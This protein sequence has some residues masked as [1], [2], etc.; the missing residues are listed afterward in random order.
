MLL[1]IFFA[2]CSFFYFP[3]ISSRSY[4]RFALTIDGFFNRFAISLM[5]LYVLLE[6]TV[7]TDVCTYRNGLLYHCH[8]GTL[9]LHCNPLCGQYFM[10]L[11]FNSLKS[12]YNF[13]CTNAG[14][15]LVYYQSTT[16]RIRVVES[17]E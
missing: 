9:L 17:N 11:C 3:Q 6:I 12:R 2:I 8:I 13:K 4:L 10:A 1:P 7:C 14:F 16:D 15:H 5:L